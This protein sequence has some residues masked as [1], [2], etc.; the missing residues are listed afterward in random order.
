[1]RAIARCSPSN[2][3]SE[4]LAAIEYARVDAQKR[5]FKGQVAL[6]IPDIFPLN[7]LEA[8]LLQIIEVAW[9]QTRSQA[10][11]QACAQGNTI[12][13]QITGDLQKIKSELQK[14]ADSM[15]TELDQ[16]ISGI[17]ARVADLDALIQNAETRITTVT[18]EIEKAK[19]E[20]SRALQQIQ[21]QAGEIS[22]LWS[23]VQAL[24]DR[25][26]QIEGSGIQNLISRLTR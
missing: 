14:Y 12:W 3:I 9:N 19:S 22:N 24:K 11:K 20:A 13:N 16:V 5:Y 25:M 7:Y 1:M 8:A 4:A 18:S 26:N 10:I 17:K 15:K 6:L 23:E 2:P 21:S